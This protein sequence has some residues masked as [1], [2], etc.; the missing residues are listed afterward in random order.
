MEEGLKSKNLDVLK[1]IT[2]HNLV[3]CFY[4]LFYHISYMN[5]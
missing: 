2:V 1:L 4:V 5:C 3:S